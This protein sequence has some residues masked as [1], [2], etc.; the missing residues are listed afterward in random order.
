[1]PFAGV[2]VQLKDEQF[3]CIADIQVKELASRFKILFLTL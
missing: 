1:V 2:E 3:V